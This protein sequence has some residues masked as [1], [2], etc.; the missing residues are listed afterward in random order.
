MQQMQ[1]YSVMSEHGLPFQPEIC[2]FNEQK[3]NQN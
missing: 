2:K 1:Q 3:L